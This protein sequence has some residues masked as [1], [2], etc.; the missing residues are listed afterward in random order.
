MA[1]HININHN[2]TEVALDIRQLN[3][4]DKINC[5]A[6]VAALEE[7]KIPV[8][9]KVQKRINNALENLKTSGRSSEMPVL[10][11]GIAPVAGLD[12][13]FEWS[14]KFDPEKLKAAEEERQ[15]EDRS[16]FY[17]QSNLIIAYK[18]DLLGILHPLTNGEAGKDV[19]GYPITPQPGADFKLDPGLNVGLLPDGVS[20]VAQCDG[21]PKME[22]TVLSVD[23]T[24]RVKS[25]VDFA[26]GNIEYNGD[27]NIKGDVKDLF[28]IRAGGNISVE[29]TVEAAEVECGGCLEVKRGISGKEKGIIRVEKN[30]STKYLSNVTVWV[31]GDIL[32]DS[33]I[34]NANLN[35]QGKVVLQ[36]GAVHGGRVT[37]AGTVEAPIIGSP[38]GVRTVIRAAID[39][40]LDHR[41]SLLKEEKK[42]CSER[43]AVLMPQA[44]SIL[45]VCQGK[46]NKQLKKMADEIRQCKQRIETVE[47][48]LKGMAREIAK[49]CTGTIIARKVIYPGAMLYIG[50]L[51][52]VVEHEVTGPV[53]LTIQR[54]GDFKELSFRVPA[55]AAAQ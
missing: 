17:E 2:K 33:E 45:A 14:E 25:D 5:E 11:R 39:P 28:R 24:L 1:W 27:V 13:Y 42:Q 8:D 26:T 32:V 16:S 23:P 55:E 47:E 54:N 41:M 15:N 10:V 49:T 46:P 29:G 40:F 18:G 22:G 30:L 50:D 3:S 19:F 4:D 35:C 12:G 53:E 38:A 6:I 36:K 21:E 37:A 9:A 52:Q 7:K 51:I 44:K 48:T 20:F 34:V 31:K 43:I